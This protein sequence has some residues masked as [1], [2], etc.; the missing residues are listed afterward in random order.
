MALH[1]FAFAL[2]AALLSFAALGQGTTK[3]T[4]SF[5]ARFSDSF[6][7]GK[8]EGFFSCT[9]IPTCVGTY[10]IQL[11]DSG[12]TNT[13]TLID[14]ITLT[15]LTITQPGPIAGVVTL[16]NVDFMDGMNG[17]GTCFIRPGTMTDRVIPYTGTWNGGTGTLA[18]STT[19][20]HGNPLTV[21]GTFTADIPAAKPVFPM[22]VTGSIDFATANIAATIQ[23]RPQD[24][25]SNGS[26]Y[27]FAVA[28]S[29]KVVNANSKEGHIGML[30]KGSPKDTPV[31]CVISQLTASGQLQAVLP[32]NLVAAVTGP[33]TSQGQAVTVLNNIATP[34]IAGATFFVGYGPNATAMINN[35]INRS[36]VSVPGALACL[37]SPPQT[38]W[39]WNPAEAGRGY[40]LEVQGNN[41]FFASYLYDVSGRST[42]YAAYGPTSLDG[43][44]FNG[45][46]LAFAH[47]Q[48]LTGAYHAAD[49]AV[50]S[51]AITLTFSDAGH[52]AMIW[53]GGA[54]PIERFN[55]V[56]NGLTATAQPVQPEN[57]WWW[58]PAESGR[59]FFVEW[60]GTGAFA[61]GYMYD[62]SGNPLWYASLATTPDTQS[63]QGS[64]LQYSNGQ[65]LTGA[66]K[67]PSSTTTDVG[68]LA[69]QFQ[70]HMDATMTLPDGRHIPITRFRF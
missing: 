23:Y 68:S 66:Y 24:V 65:T 33:L 30:A 5:G 52:G 20:D 14:A 58:N 57:G 28:P 64:L 44:L 3:V 38:G 6:G 62:A 32:A 41:I 15:G 4:G 16:K 55:I 69:I 47:G 7:S 13:F 18:L 50:Q 17:D 60:Q 39:W 49:A 70:D 12:C 22:A 51:G 2:C 35:G 25:G 36:A 63:F 29:T 8:I 40:S 46:L 61:A 53:P 21:N 31:Q 37:P 48:T 42:W 67:P 54:V 27:V 34:N 45:T 43:S 1:R 59:G 26:V 9:G 10:T 19:I 11:Q 56:A